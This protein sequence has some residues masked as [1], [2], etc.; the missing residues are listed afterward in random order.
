MTCGGR[1]DSVVVLSPEPP[2]ALDKPQFRYFK[3][4]YKLGLCFA[5]MAILISV[6]LTFGLYRIT[7]DWLR[8]GLR[9][10]IKDAISIAAHQ[11]QASD[12]NTLTDRSQENSPAYLELQNRLRLIRDAGVDYRF[13]YTLRKTPDEKIRFIVDAEED[14]KFV[15]HLGDH[16]EDAGP[17]LVHQI[18]T[19]EEPI[20]EADFYTDQWGT[21]LTGY[22]PIISRDN[23]P[24]VI[25][26]MDIAA[27]TQLQRERDFLWAALVVFGFSLPLSLITGFILGR[28][29]TGPVKDLTRG[30]EQIAGG[31]LKHLVETHGNDEVGELA[32]AFNS[33][34][35]K[36]SH[37]LGKLQ[38]NE[39]ELIRHRDNLE[40]L[41]YE[42]TIKLEDA[43]ERMS[44]DLMSAAQV[45]KAF[46]P[47]QPPSFPGLRFA[48]NFTPCDELAGD[49]L[50]ICKIDSKHIG[51]WVADVCGHGVAAA[52]ISVTLSRLLST[53]NA[54]EGGS[55]MPPPDIAEFLNERFSWDSETMRYFTFLYG[56]LNIETRV[57][58]YVSAGHPG[59]LL[60]SENGTTKILPMSPPAIGIF[61]GP[62]F[63]EHRIT[64][65]PGDRLF[66]YTDGITEANNGVGEEFG[67]DRL[68]QALAN[69][70][71]QPLQMSVESLLTD[72]T[73][74]R[75]GESPIDDLSLVAFEM[76]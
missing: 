51:I 24:K 45:Q 44:K 59:P 46:L 34:T 26:C 38:K 41:V 36:L 60:V 10:R 13:V 54:P 69:H 58:R 70:Q 12:F 43:N 63:S 37:S 23:Q 66:L 76:D 28:K 4:E 5:A 16:Y 57:F 53:L 49:M 1:I 31:D 35:R 55:N 11:F 25:L 64:L 74:W 65:A 19:M 39:I 30:A 29:L 18:D 17:T 8:E 48:W 32:N 62:K 15:S 56:V 50:D 71:K 47:Q 20:V 3:L 75:E 67:E 42:R 52:L 40:E 22:A 73:K 61:K 2:S 7:V 9:L 6:L 33:M 21:W 27:M 14:P 68:I 72:L